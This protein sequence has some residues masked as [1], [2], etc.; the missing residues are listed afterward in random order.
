M[1]P[2]IGRGPILG[3]G[4]MAGGCWAGFRVTDGLERATGFGDGAIAVDWD[5]AI[6]PVVVG[7]AV[8]AFEK[9]SGAA[10]EYWDIAAQFEI[11]S[12][13][14]AGVNGTLIGNSLI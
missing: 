12:A 9:S 8:L 1:T 11:E 4:V 13:F 2:A 10:K 14:G 3:V 6:L 7:A 5:K